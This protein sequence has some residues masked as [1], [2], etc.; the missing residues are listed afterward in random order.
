MTV[1]DE[2][3]RSTCKIGQGNECC[4]YLVCGAEGFECMKNTAIAKILDKRVE[5]KT[6]VAQGDS[7]IGDNMPDI[8]KMFNEAMGG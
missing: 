5:S 8:K 1:F 7:C 4:R 2:K 6:M 3:L